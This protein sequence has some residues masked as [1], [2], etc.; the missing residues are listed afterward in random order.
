MFSHRINDDIYLKLLEPNDAEDL[1]DITDG[2]RKYLREW[3]LGSM[4]QNQ[5]TTRNHLLRSP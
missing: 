3:Y 1:F 5:W 2:S 4:E